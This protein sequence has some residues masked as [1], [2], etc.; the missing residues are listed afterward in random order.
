[1][2]CYAC[3]GELELRHHVHEEDVGGV[4]VRNSATMAPTCTACGEVV[5][6]ARDLSMHE[7]RAAALVLRDGHRVNGEVL[8]YARKAL[9]LRQS[10]LGR[11]LDLGTEWISRWE[12]SGANATRA[13]QLAIV[14]LLDATWDRLYRGGEIEV[15]TQTPNVD[16]IEVPPEPRR[17]CG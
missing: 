13:H 14:A 6:S 3:E 4:L 10:D 7:L 8:R 2:K 16:V 12:N 5:L 1:M 9:G 11:L 17:A 15:P